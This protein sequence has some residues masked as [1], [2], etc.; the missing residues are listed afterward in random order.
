[1]SQVVLWLSG[2]W[3]SACR[4]SSTVSKAYTQ[5][6]FSLSVRMKRS[7]QPFPSGART[8]AGELSMPRKGKFLVESI[9]HVLL[10]FKRSSQHL[11]RGG[12]D[13]GWETTLGSGTTS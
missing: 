11:E 6:R 1:M 7:A 8:K 13:E 3:S 5:S 10:G 4:S 2:K 12:C 9:G